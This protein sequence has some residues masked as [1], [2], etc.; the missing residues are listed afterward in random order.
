MPHSCLKHFK[1]N[2]C[3]QII[4]RRN[5]SKDWGGGAMMVSEEERKTATTGP[6]L[7]NLLIFKGE[8]QIT[9]E[10]T[11]AEKTKIAKILERRVQWQWEPFSVEAWRSF[12]L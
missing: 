1:G 8:Q 10:Q 2:I 6:D 5:D 11:R 3:F 4:T 9:I 12:K 7:T